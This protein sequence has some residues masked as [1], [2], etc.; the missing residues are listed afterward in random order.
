MWMAFD[1]FYLT[2]A[3]AMPE[4]VLLSVWMGVGGLGMA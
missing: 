1:P 2:V 3:F 4:V